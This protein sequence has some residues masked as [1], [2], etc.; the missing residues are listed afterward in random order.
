MPRRKKYTDEMV[1][2]IR[3]NALGRT[4]KE[5]TALINKQFGTTFNDEQIHS[6][7]TRLKIRGG[8][9]SRFK[10]GNPSWNKG[11]PFPAGNNSGSFKKG[12]VPHSHLPVGSEINRGGYI[13][14]KIAEP[15]RWK[16]KHRLMWE[17]V[18][19]QLPKGSLLT[20]LDGNSLNCTLENLLAIKQAQN[21]RLNQFG[22]ARTD[23]ETTNTCLLIADISIAIGKQKRKYQGAR[24]K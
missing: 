7:K 6:L 1:L 2:F 21:V 16:Q 4:N 14:V 20:F 13:W 10:K 24:K 3:E 23:A 12:H 9:D 8:L 18:H 19:G 22:L 11:Q 17:D 15:N 5:M